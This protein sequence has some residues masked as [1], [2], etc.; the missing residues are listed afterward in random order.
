MSDGVGGCGFAKGTRRM[1]RLGLVGALVLA[2]AGCGPRTPAMTPGVV[3]P[4][5]ALAIERGRSIVAPLVRRGSGV[6]VAVGVD[7]ELVWSEGFGR[8]AMGDGPPVRPESRFRV[9]SLVKQVTAVLALQAAVRGEVDM[10]GSVRDVIRT[11]PEAYQGVTLQHL[12][13]HTAGVRHYHGESEAAMTDHCGTAAEALP[14]F[15]DDPLVAAPGARES[16][17][18]WGFVLASAVLERAAGVPFPSLLEMRILEPAGMRS[19]R[20]EGEDDPATRI[21]YYDVDEDGDVSRTPPL[22]AS[23]KMGGGGFV[24]SAEDMVR[25][26]NAILR[27]ELVPL[28]AV[29]QML[30]DRTALVAAGSGAG[31]HAVSQVDLNSRI[32]VVVVSNTS[33][34]E[35]QI[36][37]ERA[38][39]LLAAVFS[40]E[41]R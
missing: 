38:R 12:L 15:V 18:T 16:Y 41:G 3:S 27:G 13:T 31:G 39:G 11:L 19:T 10:R 37:L 21:S 30:G 33:G 2:P 34:L 40:Q 20:L 32:S 36:A 22:D 35:Q 17:S 8:T 25:F 24:A 1:V 28:A 29:R 26:H 23:C 9:Y 14:L 4:D 5:H 6:A 7:G